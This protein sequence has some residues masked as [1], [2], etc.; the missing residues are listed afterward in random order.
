MLIAKD[1]SCT[2]STLLR[3]EFENNVKCSHGMGQPGKRCFAI[4]LELVRLMPD[5]G[6]EKDINALALASC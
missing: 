2:R 1:R 3:G 6:G 4:L 5:G